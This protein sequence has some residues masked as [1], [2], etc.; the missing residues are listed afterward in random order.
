MSAPLTRR[1]G[2]RRAAQIGGAVALLAVGISLLF[3]SVAHWNP[4]NPVPGELQIQARCS[5]A[6]GRNLSSHAIR[7]TC[8]LDRSEIQAVVA[9]VLTGIDI[10]TLVEKARKSQSDDSAAIERVAERLGVS[11]DKLLE[12]LRFAANTA[13]GEKAQVEQLTAFFARDPSVE[14]PRPISAAERIVAADTK[15]LVA[16]CAAVAAGTLHAEAIDLECGPSEAEIKALVAKVISE[17]DLAELMRRSVRG[18]TRESNEIDKLS[19]QLRLSHDSVNRILAILGNE[20]T[21]T[22]RLVERLAELAREHIALVLRLAALPTEDSLIATLRDHAM[23]ALGQGDYRRCEAILAAAELTGQ[24]GISQTLSALT[25][26]IES[27]DRGE[28]LLARKDY[29]GAAGLF[30]E[31]AAAVPNES[32]LLRATYLARQSNALTVRGAEVGDNGA[33]RKAV[34]VYSAALDL[35]SSTWILQENEFGSAMRLLGERDGDHSMLE[36]SIEVHRAVLGQISRA[37]MPFDW[38]L[39]QQ[40]LGDALVTLGEQLRDKASLQQAIEAYR[41]ALEEQTQAR[42]A[43]AWASIQRS[44]AWTLYT[45]GQVEGGT[46][47]FEEAAGI[48]HDL[49]AARPRESDPSGWAA[50]QVDL[51]TVL[52]SWGKRDSGTARLEQAVAAY[53]AALEVE[54]RDRSPL[55]WATIQNN[56]AIALASLGE[57]E[58]GTSHL[59]EAVAVYRA[60]L[61]EYR[62]DRVPLR[63]AMTQMNLG[64]AL[65]VLGARESGTAR[66]EEAVIAYAAALE[67]YRSDRF[68]IDWATCT[69]GQ[70]VTL[71]LIADRVG[72]A[73]RGQTAVEQIEL[74]LALM[75]QVGDESRVTYY[76]A[77]LRKAKALLDRLAGR[78]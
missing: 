65:T 53:H 43:S 45:L 24:G 55:H 74:A 17:G 18:D 63:W 64:V 46:A 22:D 69:G 44:L 60:A 42:N 56:L 49:L 58:N 6:A 11:S 67:E 51:G 33:L 10:G 78:G 30:A 48:F 26:A 34:S 2:S 35:L 57:R 52:S 9:Q 71:M 73:G 20:G 32:L 16:D 7:I 47:R 72:D 5:V 12:G 31:A 14:V 8:G 68:P 39:T 77:G 62:R 75:R 54:T 40:Y 28:R 1:L 29:R 23:A 61:G 19:N 50:T 66:L 27:A 15:K 25:M 37:R 70:G 3:L 36:K 13:S 76:E 41:A 4:V 59:E 21:S 38:S